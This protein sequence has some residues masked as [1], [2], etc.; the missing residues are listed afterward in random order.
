MEAAPTTDG[1]KKLCLVTAGALA[2]VHLPRGALRARAKSP[3]G[4]GGSC[5]HQDE[6]RD[7]PRIQSIYVGDGRLGSLGQEIA[8]GV[9]HTE[10]FF[11][12]PSRV[13]CGLRCCV[14]G[15]YF[16]SYHQDDYL[17]RRAPAGRARAGKSLLRP[18]AG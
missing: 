8:V 6:G 9:A 16:A 18:R 7:R 2:A 5:E 1:M 13:A 11:T 12:V 14:N 10:P 3:I 17:C 15:G 4:S